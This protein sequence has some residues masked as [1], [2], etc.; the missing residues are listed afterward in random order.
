MRIRGGASAADAV[1]TN[2]ESCVNGSTLRDPTGAPAPATVGIIGWANSGMFAWNTGWGCTD[3]TLKV[4]G[5]E[6]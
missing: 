6:N 1:G 3:T 2:A 4:Y 5:L